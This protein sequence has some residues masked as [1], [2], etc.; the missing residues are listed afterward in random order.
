MAFDGLSKGLSELKNTTA[1][2][3]IEELCR[4]TERELHSIQKAAATK[5][6]AAVPCLLHIAA[7]LI[8]NHLRVY[9]VDDVC[10]YR[11]ITPDPAVC[12]FSSHLSPAVDL[13]GSDSNLAIR[14]LISNLQRR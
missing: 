8:Y 13:L 2:A 7:L 1:T 9:L 10:T 5:E 11:R 6:M 12:N 4:M 14:N 3:A